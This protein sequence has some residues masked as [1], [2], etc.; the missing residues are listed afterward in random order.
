M[1]SEISTA[2]LQVR[3]SQKDPAR[4]WCAP[5]EHSPWILTRDDDYRLVLK[6]ARQPRQRPLR[7]DLDGQEIQRRAA[8]G[9]K[10]LLARALGFKGGDYH[11]VDMTA[12]LGRDAATCARLGMTVDAYERN[13]LIYALLEDAWQASSVPLKNRLKI[14]FGKASARQWQAGDA[15]LYDPM[16]PVESGKKG[17]A[18]SLEIQRLREW[19]GTDDDV[20]TTFDALRAMPPK[21]LAVKRPPRGQRVRLAKPHVEFSSGRVHWEVYLA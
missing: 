4:Q 2:S 21:R 14:H 18:P 1:I 5:N 9:K 8:Q 3:L 6:D 11:V 10:S 17:A 7:I 13:P 20:D 16:Y 15:T 12:G 19:I